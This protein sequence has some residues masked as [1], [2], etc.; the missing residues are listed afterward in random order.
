MAQISL[1]GF[2]AQAPWARIKV[3]AAGIP[4][5][6]WCAA[7]ALT[8][9]FVIVEVARVRWGQVDSAIIIALLLIPFLVGLIASGKLSEFK[10]PGGIEAKF[11]QTAFEPVKVVSETI[12]YSD[13]PQLLPKSHGRDLVERT[14]KIDDSKPSLMTMTVGKPRYEVDALREHLR[15]LTHLRNFKLVVFLDT[16]GRFFAHVSPLSLKQLL[17]DQQTA[18]DFVFAINEGNKAHL[19]RYPCVVQ[20]AAAPT[21]TNADVLRQMHEQNVDALAVVD[22]EGQL[23]GVVQREQVLSRMM[24]AFVR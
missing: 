8:L 11:A 2:D 16:G 5:P 14:A 12:A 23:R 17:A 3:L 4:Q 21:A 22:A 19:L 10:A 13:D 9:A 18:E 7:G 1:R 6:A 20:K 15:A 24:L